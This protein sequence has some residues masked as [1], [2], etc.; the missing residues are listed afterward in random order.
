METLSVKT[1]LI[2][3]FKFRNKKCKT[4]QR[5]WES[6]KLFPERQAYRGVVQTL[7]LLVQLITDYKTSVAIP[8][9]DSLISQMQDRFSDEDRHARH[10]LYLVPSII[11]KTPRI[12]LKQQNACCSG[13]MT[14]H[15]PNPLGM[16]CE[17][18]K[19]CGSQQRRIFQAIFY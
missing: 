15:F 2:S 18:G 12:Y 16:S 7:P 1:T 14:F 11:V 3:T 17:D 10:L 4:L 5:N 6:L 9:L 13:R 19:R 8:L